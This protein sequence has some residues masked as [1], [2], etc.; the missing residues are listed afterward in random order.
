MYLGTAFWRCG[1]VVRERCAAAVLATSIILALTLAGSAFAAEEPS[2]L[3]AKKPSKKEEDAGRVFSKEQPL[4]RR[5]IPEVTPGSDGATKAIIVPQPSPV[6]AD[7][8]KTDRPVKSKTVSPK[9]SKSI[10]DREKKGAATTKAALKQK[11]E[12]PSAGPLAA[13][14]IINK[15]RARSQAKSE[16]AGAQSGEQVALPIR[17]PAAPVARRASPALAAATAKTRAGK[18]V[19]PAG[20]TSRRLSQP[21]SIYSPKRGPAATANSAKA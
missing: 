19:R 5:Q 17:K 9:E 12:T 8:V 10:A 15:A 18:A 11:T 16:T 3:N 7:P 1:S 14:R 13:P 2:G 4:F 20:R 21:S 6:K